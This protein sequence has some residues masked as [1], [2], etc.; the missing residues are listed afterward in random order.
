MRGVSYG[1]VPA[2]SRQSIR[3]RDVCGPAQL[4]TTS[5]ASRLWAD[6]QI[7]ARENVSALSMSCASLPSCGKCLYSGI[8]FHRLSKLRVHLIC[9]NH[10][11]R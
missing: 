10:D 7:K 11:V 1:L 4:R 9:D 5:N 8:A 6:H 3:Q 2:R